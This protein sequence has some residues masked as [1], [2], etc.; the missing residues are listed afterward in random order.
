LEKP[1]TVFGPD[2][3]I[4]TKTPVEISVVPRILKIIVGKLT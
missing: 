2:N 4:I 1:L 3:Q